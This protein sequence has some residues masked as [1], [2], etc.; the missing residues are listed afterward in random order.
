MTHFLFAND[1]LLFCR[2]AL[3][4]CSKVMNLLSVYEKV[5]RQNVN[6]EKTTLIF[7]KAVMEATRQIINGILGVHEILGVAFF[8]RKRKNS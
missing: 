3:V 5:S 6:K 8:D 1:S 2:A 4:E 7:S